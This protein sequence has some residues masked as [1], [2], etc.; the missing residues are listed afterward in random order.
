M[1]SNTSHRSLRP[2]GWCVVLLLISTQS[3]ADCVSGNCVNGQGTYTLASGNKYVGEFKGTAFN[4]QGTYTWANG[5]T[6][7]GEFRDDK[8]HGQ[9]TYTYASG[10]KYVGEHKDGK[11]HGQG[12]WTFSNGGK[13]VGEYR[14]DKWHGQ[15]TYTYFSG[16]QYVGEYVGEWKDDKWHGQGTYTYA[17]GSKYVGEWKDAKYHGQGTYTYFSGTQ[18]VGEYVGEHK[19]G[20]RNGQGTYTDPDG[21]KYV[22]EFRDGDFNGQGTGTYAD[23]SK[24]V[25]EWKD[26]KRHGQGTGTFGDGSVREGIWEDDD[27][28]AATK[29]EHEANTEKYDQ[30]LGE[31]EE[32][33]ITVDS[34]GDPLTI[35]FSYE[36]QSGAAGFLQNWPR[37]VVNE[38]EQ[39]WRLGYSAKIG[40]YLRLSNCNSNPCFQTWADVPLD[41]ITPLDSIVPSSLHPLDILLTDGKGCDRSNVE[42]KQCKRLVLGFW[43]DEYERVKTSLNNDRYKNVII[44][45]ERF[46]ESYNDELNDIYAKAEGSNATN[47]WLLK[48]IKFMK[49]QIELL[50][51]LPLE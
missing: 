18:Y 51:M 32:F 34:I 5:D 47:V 1:Q 17:D 19:D 6:Y 44:N 33:P 12:T 36:R 16:T 40:P 48:K 45:L 43:N 24:Y 21:S 20:K 4:G 3:W 31:F 38:K 7:V 37:D 2:F 35:Y 25:G 30:L 23:G 28:I 29:A 22:G 49:Y 15:G 50:R 26:D 42:M 14:D 9:G 27:Y 46:Y 39:N 41:K 11:K 8:W 13:Y 10:S